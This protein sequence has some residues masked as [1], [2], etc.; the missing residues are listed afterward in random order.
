MSNFT[1]K[2]KLGPC[3]SNPIGGI[4][5]TAVYNSNANTDDGSWCVFNYCLNNT[6]ANYVCIDNFELCETAEG[7][8]CTSSC[9]D[10]TP[11]DGSG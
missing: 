7:T 11:I 10:G 2:L 5:E 3:K 4:P 6:M 1:F 8:Q 9:P